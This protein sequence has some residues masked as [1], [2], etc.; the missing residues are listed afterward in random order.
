MSGLLFNTNIRKANLF[1]VIWILMVISTNS[2]AQTLTSQ[3]DF[4]KYNLALGKKV[5]LDNYIKSHGTS[6][7]EVP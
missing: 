7:A 2:F 4:R 1:L 3:T 6:I 5:F